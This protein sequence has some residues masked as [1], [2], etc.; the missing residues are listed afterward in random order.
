VTILGLQFGTLIGGAVITEYVFA[1]PGVGRLV[2]DSIFARDY[3][4]VQGVILLI[5]IGLRHEQPDRG[6]HLRVVG[7][8]DSVWLTE[9]QGTRR[10][11]GAG[12]R[13]CPSAPGQG[14]ARGPA[15]TSSAAAWGHSM[16]D[17]AVAA[18]AVAV[19]SLAR[20]MRERRWTVLK[21]AA[22]AR[23]APLGA[24]VLLAALLIALLASFI[25]PYDPL[26]QDLLNTLKPPDGVHLL[27]TDNLG[28]DVL[29][30]VI[31]GTRVSLLAGFASVA[32]AVVA[33]S[34]LGLAAGFAGGRADG[35]LMRL[36][37]AVL[38]FPPWCWRWRSAR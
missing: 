21:R 11:V 31:F 5:A 22:S 26:Q 37:D 28:R 6:H 33:G 13:A 3:P 2:V 14:Q 4:L 35:T 36:M 25:S 17:Q 18:G 15:P 19:P 38:S 16:A 30:R 9:G 8:E 10:T 27:G 12:P 23:M 32:I 34:L 24:V 1:L 20:P 7:P 29:A